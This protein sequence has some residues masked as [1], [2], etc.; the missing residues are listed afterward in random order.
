LACE[1]SPDSSDVIDETIDANT[2]AA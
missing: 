1:F 2:D